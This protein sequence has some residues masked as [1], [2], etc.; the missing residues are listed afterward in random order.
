MR[1][2]IEGGG[3][4]GGGGEVGGEG[5]VCPGVN[6]GFRKSFGGEGEG[7]GE[8]T[9]H[10]DGHDGRVGDVDRADRSCSYR[11]VRGREFDCEI[12]AGENR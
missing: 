9:Y 7:Q 2:L 4:E 12:C 3:A 5:Y 6:G 8:G 1:L 11:R 10:E